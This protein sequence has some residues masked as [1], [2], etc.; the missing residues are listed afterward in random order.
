VSHNLDISQLDISRACLEYCFF[1]PNYAISMQSDHELYNEHRDSLWFDSA[2][3]LEPSPVLEDE[4][5]ADVVVIGAGYTG[6]RAA[7][8]L[9]EAG[10]RVVVLDA[11]DI[12][13]GASGR[14]G[15]QV[16]PMLP[17]NTPDR[18]RKLVGDNYFESLTEASLNSADELFELIETYKIDCQPRQNGWLRVDHCDKARKVSQ[19]NA[20]IWNRLGA[21]M[22]PVEGDE[23]QRLSGSAI[24]RSG[25]VV[26]KGGSVQPLSLAR[27]LAR[28][29]CEAGAEIYSRSP[30]SALH[31]KGAKWLVET[32]R[33]KVTTDWVILA[34]NGYSDKLFPGL[35]K[36]ILPLVPIQIATGP[37]EP[38]Q[39]AEILPHGHTISDTRRIIMYARRE[40]DDRMVFGGHGH[41][42]QNNEAAGFDW[43]VRDA[44]RIF[45]Q[46]K[47]VDWC[48]R[49][50]GKIAVTE[51]RL[52]HFHEPKPGLIA[53]L[54]Y[55]GRGVAMSHVMGKLLADRA[56][57]ALPESLP[58]PT[59]SIKAMSFRRIQ[60][61]GE[62]SAIKLMRFLD[63][64]ESK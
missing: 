4:T 52:P 62:S 47:G 53:G 16:N 15:G 45:P 5:N 9:A 22:Q 49:W 34:T 6:L 60:M 42:D 10:T 43:L 56:L 24:Y 59:T 25:V 55:N 44:E 30:V 57:G 17:F 21:D 35:A 14:N 3:E 58:F 54:G 37:L 1:V 27:G 41:L 50:G 29:A 32:P 7:L 20:E 13:W 18:I 36:S 63:K 19:A 46:L 8:R 64:L 31:R 2:I 38:R 28:A 61:M 33:A 11:F 48:Y 40:Q 12:G 51:D 26:P 39:I 23:V